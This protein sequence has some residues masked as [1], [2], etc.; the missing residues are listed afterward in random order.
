MLCHRVAASPLLT[1]PH[2]CSL[3]LFRFSRC[4]CVSVCLS[5]SVLIASIRCVFASLHELSLTLSRLAAVTNSAALFTVAGLCC[6]SYLRRVLWLTV[7]VCQTSRFT[8]AD[9]LQFFKR[10]SLK[11][12]MHRGSGTRLLIWTN[13][14]PSAFVVMFSTLARTCACVWFKKVQAGDDLSHAECKHY[15]H[16][17]PEYAWYVIPAQTVCKGNASPRRF[18]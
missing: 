1:T 15:E 2:F 12:E 4:F 7:C 10:A 13:H 9:H 6:F 18:T 5:L 17:L 14:F 8:K 11:R 3:S 16:T